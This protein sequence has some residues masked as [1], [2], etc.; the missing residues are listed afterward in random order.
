MSASFSTDDGAANSATAN[1]DT[2]WG[3]GATYVSDVG[4]DTKLTIGAGIASSSAGKTGTALTNDRGG[5]HVGISAVTGDLTVAVGYGDGDTIVDDGA[6]GTANDSPANTQVA[7]SVVSAGVSYKAD[8]KI[9][10]GIILSF[11][12]LCNI[13][14]NSCLSWSNDIVGSSQYQIMSSF[15]LK[16]HI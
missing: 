14:W 11:Q 2:S 5:F 10:L 9:T 12:F 4:D 8:D 3:V 6:I 7:G 15:L 13:S 16:A 1:L